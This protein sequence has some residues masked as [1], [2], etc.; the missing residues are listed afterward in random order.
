[1]LTLLSLHRCLLICLPHHS[2]RIN[3]K[4]CCAIIVVLAWINTCSVVLPPLFGWGYFK[5]ECLGLSCGP[6]WDDPSNSSYTS[7]LLFM[8][9]VVPGVVIT[10]TSVTLVVVMKRHSAAIQLASLKS[11]MAKRELR[12][13]KM[14]MAMTFSFLGVWSPY[15]ICAILVIGG[16][17]DLLNSP[18]AV[19]P[20]ILAKTSTFTNPMLYVMLN[21]QFQRAF[22]RMVGLPERTDEQIAMATCKTVVTGRNCDSSFLKKHS[23]RKQRAGNGEGTPKATRKQRKLD[24]RSS[25]EEVSSREHVLGPRIVTGPIV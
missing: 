9:F 16:K 19:V 23:R 21:P 6:A 24:Q 1:M 22:R 8:G 2:A 4:I 10:V 7:Y 12:V 25:T 11:S 17:S 20:L 15:A 14:V 13:T 5:L 18:A 3:S